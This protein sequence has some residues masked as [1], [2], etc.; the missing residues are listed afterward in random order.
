MKYNTATILP[1]YDT[2]TWIW[3]LYSHRTADQDGLDMGKGGDAMDVAVEIARDNNCLYIDFDTQ[4]T[5]KSWKSST[6]KHGTLKV[7]TRQMRVTLKKN[8]KK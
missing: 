2:R 3:T 5:V 7:I 8:K 6:K 1:S 4:R